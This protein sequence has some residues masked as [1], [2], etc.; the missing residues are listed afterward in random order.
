MSHPIHPTGGYRS[1]AAFQMATI[2]YDA[3]TSFCEKFIDGKSRTADQMIQAARSG[4]QNIAE[5]SRAGAINPETERKL[6]NV[7]RAS[8]EE[9]LLD[10]ED[11]LRQR[12]LPQWECNAPEAQEVREVWQAHRVEE[13]KISDLETNWR[14]LDDEHARWYEK[15]LKDAP[16]VVQ[17]NA[18]ICLI[19]QANYRLDLLLHPRRGT[20]MTD[21]HGEKCPICG[22]PM[23][24]RIVKSGPKEGSRFWGCSRYPACKGTRQA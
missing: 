19:N 16:A 18:A 23:V 8:L 2:I 4:R 3:T 15:W 9:L 13:K 1:L 24:L 11:Y 17:A 10:Y 21:S 5:G 14:R 20:E 12:Q 7:A 6:T 22:A